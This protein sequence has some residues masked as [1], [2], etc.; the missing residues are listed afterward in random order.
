MEA[1]NAFPKLRN[2]DLFPAEVSGQRV[3]CLR[4]PLSLSQKVLFIP[5]SA[6]FIIQL[7]DG[8]HSVVDIQVEYMR[9]FGELLYREKIQELVNQMDEHLFLDSERFR[10]MKKKVIEAFKSDPARPLALAGEA[11]EEDAGKLRQVIEGYFLEPDGPG[12]PSG[13]R[14]ADGLVAAIAPHID[15][16]RGGPCYAWAHKAIQESSPA[17]LFIILGTAHSPT[18]QPFALTQKDFQT[19]WGLVETDR[20]FLSEIQAR[21]PL[22]LYE[23]VHKAEHSIELQLIFLR[24]LWSKKDP[25]QIIPVLCGSFHEAIAKNISPMDLPGVAPFIEAMKEAIGRSRRKV[26]LLAS[27]DLAHVG[28]RFGDAEA[29]N[30]FTLESLGEKDR[31]LLEFA[32]RVDAEGF[33]NCLLRERDQRRICGFPPIYTL[34]QVVEAR[35][36]NL[37]KY[38]Q[39]MDPAG[40]S[41]VTFAS[42]AF[43]S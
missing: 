2:V 31:V 10:Q 4:D 11:Y 5:Y 12:L 26:C 9:Q 20:D 24:A 13:R 27:A 21:C 16:R 35:E 14:E 42:L 28:L 29:P 19:P 37:L 32:R 40:Q 17:D 7:F 34:L 23:F 6:L 33:Y 22:D 3:I 39:S 38:G 43:F 18:Q 30:R 1:K 15:Y 8:R 25:F 36:G 41:V